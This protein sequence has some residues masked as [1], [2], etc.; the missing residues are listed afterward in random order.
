MVCRNFDN[1]ILEIDSNFWLL[2]IYVTCITLTLKLMTKVSLIDFSAVALHRDHQLGELIT[3]MVCERKYYH[4][5]FMFERLKHKEGKKGQEGRERCKWYV[6]GHPGRLLQS[7][8]MN[9]HFSL[10]PFP[11]LTTYK[12]S[13]HKIRVR[14]YMGQCYCVWWLPRET[15]VFTGAEG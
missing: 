6:Q 10:H 7:E 15:H 1:P 8:K 14:V 13:T 4:P 5:H 9:P 12:V 11:L 2:N 3:W